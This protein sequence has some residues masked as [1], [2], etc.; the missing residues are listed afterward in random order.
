MVALWRQFPMKDINLRTC[1]VEGCENK[2]KSN[3]YC[4]KHVQA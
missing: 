4:S 1:S 3:G 2:I